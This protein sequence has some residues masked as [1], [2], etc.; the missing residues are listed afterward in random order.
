MKPL[1]ALSALL[2]LAALDRNTAAQVPRTGLELHVAPG[3]HDTDEGTASRPFATLARARD[4]VRAIK[5]SRGLPPGG[6]TVTLHGGLYELKETFELTADDSGSATAPIVYR[7]RPGD[8]VRVSGGKRVTGWK[9]VTE[10]AVLER[11]GPAARGQVV[12]ADLRALGVT[13]FGEMGGGF[14]LRGGPGLELFFNDAPMTLSRYPNEGFIKITGVEGLT[15]VAWGNA[16]GRAEGIFT[17]EGDRP[18]RWVSEK[19]GWVL[20]YWFH[21]WAEQRHRIESIDVAAK[22]ITVKKP[23]HHYGYRKGRWFYGF[24]LLCEID[25]PGE[26]YLDHETGVLYFWPPSAI[27]QGEAMVSVLTSVVTM[28]DASHVTL[29]GLTLELARGTALRIEGAASNRVVGCTLR[30]MGSWAVSLSGANSAV[31]GCDI[32][33][34]GDGGIDLRGGDRRTLTPAGLSAENNHIHHWSRWNRMNRH[35]ISLS[36]VGHRAAH[37]LLHHSPHAAIDFRGN[38]HVI[39][40]NEIHDVCEEANDSGA[41]YAGRN[42]T[43]RGTVIRYNYLHHIRGFEGRGCIGI[44]LDDMYSGTSI[45]GN[46]FHQVPR[47]AY[48]GGGH[49]NRIENNIFVDCKPSVHVD[50]RGLGW[51]YKWP[52]DWVKEIKEKGT[53]SG[54]RYDQP[55]YSERYPQLPRILDQEPAAP[56]GSL[57]A[58]NVQIGGSWDEVDKKARPFVTF[59]DNLV[60]AERHFTEATKENFQLPDDSPAYKL[61]FQ[62][63][64][65]E[66]MGLVNDG[67]RASW[68]A[69]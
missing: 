24:N 5:T 35:G 61:G 7:A 67:T 13:D 31:V 53:L 60:G 48:I 50:S 23:Y 18:E 66:K 27:D 40:F 3:G 63:I 55:P 62:R 49:D 14:N 22:R 41:I 37:N 52:E 59:Q 42:W 54:I 47:A 16:K 26:W 43:M 30:N 8:E 29:Q 45:F 34:T 38:D 11:L 65:I 6:V 69:K 20:G 1:L 17:Y 58:R 33:G 44:Y 46:L 68:P 32:Y 51:A 10:P 28:N 9:P 12:Q 25:Q 15:E 36:G 19:D 64:P 2:A 39:E 57:I 4:E 21:D 56:T